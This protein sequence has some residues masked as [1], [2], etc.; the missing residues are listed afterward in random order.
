MHR[1]LVNLYEDSFIKISYFTTVEAS[2]EIVISFSSTPL[3]A[4]GESIAKEQFIGALSKADIPGIFIIDKLASYGNSLDFAL[5]ASKIAPLILGKRVH[6]VGYCMGGFLATVMSKHINVV[7]VV[8]I[9]PQWSIHPDFL[10]AESYLNVFTNKIDNWRIKSL[11]DFFVDTTEYYIFN[12]NDPDDQHQIQYFPTQE[13]VHI[14]EFGSKFGHDLPAVLDEQLDE[15]MMACLN[16]MP[17][18]VEKFIK[19]YY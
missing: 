9:T 3:L 1:E 11:E 16:D 15:L 10:P 6:A 17:E 13:N 7:N 14:F 5:I 4:Q 8:A 18:V 12:S 2:E 19:E